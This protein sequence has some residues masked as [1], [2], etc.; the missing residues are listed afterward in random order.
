MKTHIDDTQFAKLASQF[1]ASVKAGKGI[2]LECVT[3]S[4]KRTHYF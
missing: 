4:L 3:F 2:S 1:R